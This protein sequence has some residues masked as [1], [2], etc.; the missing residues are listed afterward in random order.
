MKL[1]DE[2]R[3]T[4]INSMYG[5]TYFVLS[6]WVVCGLIAIII[7]AFIYKELN[8]TYAVVG[9]GAAYCITL[10]ACE[11]V[12]NKKDE[13]P[14]EI[15]LNKN[16]ICDYLS[17]NFKSVKSVH[18]SDYTKPGKGQSKGL[19]LADTHYIV[20]GSDKKCFMYVY[21]NTKK[22][23][24]VLLKTSGKQFKEIKKEHSSAC[25]S[26]FPKVSSGNKFYKLAVDSSYTSEQ[27]FEIINVAVNELTK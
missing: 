21:E 24:I 14:S 19:L 27:L 9:I 2:K 25:V 12:R 16:S 23:V 13:K 22:E 18:R 4:K 8:F 20:N 17:S 6:I 7:L 11:I 1:N 3:L 5:L 15:V 26:N 10:L